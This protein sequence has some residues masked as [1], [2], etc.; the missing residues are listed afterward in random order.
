MTSVF[1]PSCTPVEDDGTSND[2][3]W[4]ITFRLLLVTAFLAT[5]GCTQLLFAVPQGDCTEV[6]GRHGTQAILLDSTSISQSRASSHH[7]GPVDMVPLIIGP[8]LNSIGAKNVQL[9]AASGDTVYSACAG[10]DGESRMCFLRNPQLL[11]AD[12]ELFFVV[13]TKVADWE[14]LRDIQE[15][16]DL[17]A[18]CDPNAGN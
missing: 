12:A 5:A 10:Y 1:D 8:E 6:H 18:S 3:S 17:I 14:V 15:Y 7:G 2:M 16:W 9:R 4:T 11:A 13:A